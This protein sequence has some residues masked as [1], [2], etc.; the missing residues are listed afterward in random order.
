MYVCCR[1][2]LYFFFVFF[3]LPQT[4]FTHFANE[5]YRYTQFFILIALVQSIQAWL[6]IG[7]RGT[8]PISILFT[9]SK[10]GSFSSHQP[11]L[12]TFFYFVPVLLLF[13]SVIIVHVSVKA[14]DTAELSRAWLRFGLCIHTSM[15]R[16]TD[17]IM[18]VCV[19]PTCMFER[20]V[21]VSTY[22]IFIG[23]HISVWYFI[24]I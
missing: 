19:A 1:L 20:Y 9:Y 6:I 15:K 17:S 12:N 11:T 16:V 14:P 21:Y 4:H 2:F 23:W 5:N 8:S 7:E 24:Y 13:S 10:Y 22:T 18:C 3:S